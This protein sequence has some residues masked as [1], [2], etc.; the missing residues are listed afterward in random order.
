M[1]GVKVEISRGLIK[2]L[3]ADDAAKI[4]N[5]IA[6]GLARNLGG[7]I[8]ERV[9]GSGNLAGQRVP[10]WADGKRRLVSARYPSSAMG[11][12]VPS[13]AESFED[14]Q[15]FHREAGARRGT[16]S[17]SGGKWAGLALVIWNELKCDL[18]FRGRSEGQDPRIIEGKSRPIK[19]S[20]ALK[21]WTVYRAFRVQ[22]M[23]ISDRELSATTEAAT[24]AAALMAASA[25]PVSF[26][27]NAPRSLDV[28]DLFKRALG[29]RIAIP[30]K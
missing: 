7:A 13:G 20:N 22:F 3:G 29:N 5:R 10:Q 21:A 9:Q 4:A 30:Q 6:P 26:T 11:S 28:N 1:I 18:R 12:P 19:V 27:T 17:V 2:K 8:R 16:M 24:Q 14:S 15:T 25:L 23:A